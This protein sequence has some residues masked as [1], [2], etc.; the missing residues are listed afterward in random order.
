MARQVILFSAHPVHKNNLPSTKTP[1][2][3]DDTTKNKLPS[4]K[5]PLLVDDTTKNKLPS[6][7]QPFWW[8]RQLKTS[9]RPQKKS[10]PPFGVSSYALAITRRMLYLLGFLGVGVADVHG[11]VGAHKCIGLDGFACP[12]EDEREFLFL[13]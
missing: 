1:L 11:S 9:S 4:T 13:F 6:T 12:V 3:V 7:K 2:F 8:M 10:R 5:K